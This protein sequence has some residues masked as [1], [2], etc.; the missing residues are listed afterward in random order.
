M[1]IT[2]AIKLLKEQQRVGI[3][4]ILHIQKFLE[5]FSQD[6]VNFKKVFE[7][8]TQRQNVRINTI[9]AQLKTMTH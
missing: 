2:L 9:T 7:N 3:D 8:E 1:S 4:N 6:Y 5:R